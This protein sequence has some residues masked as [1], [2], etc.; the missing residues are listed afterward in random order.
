MTRAASGDSMWP[1]EHV[2]FA[3]VFYAVSVHLAYRT[4]PADWP[5]VGLATGA[6]FPDVVDKPLSWQFGLVPTGWGPAHSL[7]VAVPLVVTVYAV[8]RRR[9]A[10]AVGVAFGVGY[11]LHLPADLI[12]ASLGRGRLYLAPVLWPVSSPTT[13]HEP[14]SLVAG[15]LA[16]FGEYTADLAALDPTPSLVLQLGTLTVGGLL[17]LYDGTPGLAAPVGLLR[18]VARTVRPG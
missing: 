5:T 14:A 15:I 16:R 4:A 13:E 12:P 7:F 10:P 8:A 6:L 1:W 2:L 17:W 18:T 3:Y 11:L 9:G